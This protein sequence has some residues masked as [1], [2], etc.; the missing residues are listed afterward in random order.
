M[1]LDSN[2][3]YKANL[4]SRAFRDEIRAAAVEMGYQVYPTQDKG[5]NPLRLHAYTP[6]DEPIKIPLTISTP[7]GRIGVQPI[8]QKGRGNGYQNVF[9]RLL[10]TA[11]AY[12]F[13]LAIIVRGGGFAGDTAP[14]RFY[15][16][17]RDESA[18]HPKL[19]FVGTM[20]EFR[21]Y[22]ATLDSIDTTAQEVA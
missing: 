7:K 6:W 10:A 5:N 20:K 13:P 22:L 16:Y 18:N 17:F 21:G 14:A 3:T 8:I 11:S 2:T 19:A 4:A 12:P 9:F 15:R 1:V